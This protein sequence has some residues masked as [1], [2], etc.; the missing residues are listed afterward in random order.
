VASAAYTVE[1]DAVV[2]NTATI[3]SVTDN[4]GALTGSLASGDTT[5]DAQWQISGKLATAQYGRV[6][7]Y[8]NGSKIATIDVLGTNSWSYTTDPLGSGAHALTAKFVN[9][10]GVAGAASA[11]FNLT[12]G[13][14]DGI[15]TPVTTGSVDAVAFSNS[16]QTLDFT[17]FT[18]GVKSIDKVDL[19]AFGGNVVKVSA[20]DVFEANTGLFT[21][22]FTFSNAQDGT[23]ASTYHQMLLTGSGSALKGASTVQLAEAANV[24]TSAWALTGT[25]QNGADMYNVYTNLTTND[26]QLLINQKLAVIN[27]VL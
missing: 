10:A 4:T 19:G 23:N 12:L 20:A 24:N 8:D 13:S 5:D 21:S 16:G 22:G 15:L 25:A 27:A 7:L 1:V 3:D 17:Q 9:T 18:A 26:Q 6:E 11:A 2:S 14:Q